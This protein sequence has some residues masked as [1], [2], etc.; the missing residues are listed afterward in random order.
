MK[1]TRSG[2]SITGVFVAVGAGVSVS[3]AVGSG[4]CV[5]SGV[6]VDVCSNVGGGVYV[7]VGA[8]GVGVRVKVAVGGTCVDVA[9][10]ALGSVDVL[11]GVAA[12]GGVNVGVDSWARATELEV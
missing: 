8:M 2:P 11:F 6:E 3:V 4:V 12:G 5:L 1:S 10:G 7:E 9:V